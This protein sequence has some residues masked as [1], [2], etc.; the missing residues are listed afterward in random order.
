MDDIDVLEDL[1]LL[2]MIASRQR[3][4]NQEIFKTRKN[5]GFYSSGVNVLIKKNRELFIKSTRFTYEQFK[6]LLNLV[7]PYLRK[8]SHRNPIEPEQRLYI[9]L[10]FLAHG[11]ALRVL[12]MKFRIGLETARSIILE[13]CDVLWRVLESHYM[14]PH[15]DAE[16]KQIS[17]D[18]WNVT[19]LPHCLGAIDGKHVAINC[20]P[21]SR[22]KYFNNKQFNSIILLAACDSS[23]TFTFVDVGAYGNQSD[24]GVF[25]NSLF[26]NMISDKSMDAPNATNLPNSDIVFPYYFVADVEF[27]LERN[28]MKPYE[29]V[30]DVS[31]EVFNQRL[32]SA[33]MRIETAFDLLTSRWRVLSTSISFSPENA[34][35][36]ILATIILHNFLKS[37]NV[38]YTAA[39][40]ANNH[41][42]ASVNSHDLLTANTTSSQLARNLRNELC[43]YLNSSLV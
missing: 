34:K 29:T 43:E 6:V 5:H 41:N 7:E 38:N 32:C 8:Y 4:G 9:T 31:E 19:K 20:P 42:L 22:S 14:S 13:T 24:G 3:R 36:V 33:R 15:S 30:T 10:H 21:N 27:P 11:R 39:E 40:K 26:R 28:I 1:L 2:K 18:F 37:G 25:K 35:K 17:E 12:S 23:Y 16:W